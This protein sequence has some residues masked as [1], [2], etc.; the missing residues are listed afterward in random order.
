MAISAELEELVEKTKDPKTGKTNESE[1]AR[2]IDLVQQTFRLARKG[3][4]GHGVR[5]DVLA[6]LK[7]TMPKLLSKHKI[8]T[9]GERRYEDYPGWT[10]AESEARETKEG[11]RL[12]WAIRGARDMVV[13]RTPKGGG[14]ATAEFV[15]FMA[16]HVRDTAEDDER[17]KL[18]ELDSEERL[19]LLR[20]SSSIPINRGTKP[21]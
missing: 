11:S 19:S 9:A 6:A 7:T 10:E 12:A 20:G 14:P 4:F 21:K 15:I 17:M 16:K 5:D 18:E 13:G 3:Q 8:R 2:R 1:A